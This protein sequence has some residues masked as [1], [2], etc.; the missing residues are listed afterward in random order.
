MVSD[1]EAAAIQSA[2]ERGGEGAAASEVRRLFPGVP[3]G[4]HARRCARTIAGWTP[5]PSPRSVPHRKGVAPLG[6]RQ[7]RYPRIAALHREGLTYPAIAERLGM[8]VSTVGHI[9]ALMVASG[10]LPRRVRG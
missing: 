2:W 1:S 4:E 9:V 10:E 7:E 8:K 3:D 6:V 5:R